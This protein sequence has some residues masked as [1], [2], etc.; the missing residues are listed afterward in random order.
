MDEAKL[1]MVLVGCCP[2]G[3]HTEQHDVFFGIGSSLKALVPELK[4]FWPEAS[5]NLHVDAWREVTRQDGFAISVTPRVAGAAMASGSTTVT[6]TTTA[7]TTASVSLANAGAVTGGDPKVPAA[8]ALFFIN[9][10]GYKKGEFDEFH[11]KMIIAAADKGVA[12]QRS[13]QTAFYQHTGYPGA[14]SHVDDKYGVDVDDVYAID[15]I[16]PAAMKEA[17]AIGLHPAADGVEDEV[18][19]GYFQLHKL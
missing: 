16:L 13:K 18:H 1:F 15:D 14:T 19:L 8:P 17:W 7:P 9:L 11:Y 3:R 2:P 12:I 4:A 10:G 5:K 6:P